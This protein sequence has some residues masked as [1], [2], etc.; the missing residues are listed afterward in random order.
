VTTSIDD[1]NVFSPENPDHLA[2]IIRSANE[3]GGSLIPAGG[4]TAL[5]IGNQIPDGA[6]LLDLTELSGVLSYQPADLTVSVAAGT[7]VSDLMAELAT[8]GQELPVD[9]PLPTIATVGGLVAS[10]F[11]GPRRLGSG[12]LKDLILGCSYVRG[13]G[14]AAKAGGSVVKN[15]SGFE[16]PRL[17]HGSWGSLAAISSV[18]FK[19][20]PKPKAEL[21]V[22]LPIDEIDRA[23]DVFHEVRSAFPS[24]TA[25]EID[26][27]RDES[28]MLV[29][30]M[31]RAE[32]LDEQAN[33]LRNTYGGEL[34]AD[35]ETSP[36]F[37]QERIDRWAT[38]NSVQV[39][40][41]GST[42]TVGEVTSVVL[43]RLSMTVAEIETVISAGAG[44]ARLRFGPGA[45]S[46][47]DLV[48]RIDLATLP[49]TTR[50]IVECAPDDW[51]ADIDVW[52]ERPD[53]VALM[54]AVKAQFDPN[55]V[56]NPGRLFI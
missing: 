22:A 51:K 36:S 3:G 6:R 25:I 4:R 11:A 38:T 49:E 41:S 16:I 32:A 56:L 42:R 52:G 7:R 8:H 17:L 19:V 13:D 14:L 37:W 23:G 46:S 34:A 31:G 43:E 54:K 50:M 47:G 45:L 5:A 33:G 30:L 39:V 10:G 26:H 21:T 48:A 35:A 2:E 40:L 28:I 20:T 9:V 15:V 55:A 53:G 24:S 27:V 1:L 44:A 29:R 18:N 12:T